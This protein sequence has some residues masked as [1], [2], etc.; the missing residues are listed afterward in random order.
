MTWSPDAPPFAT[1]NIL[2]FDQTRVTEDGKRRVIAQGVA[3]VRIIER[4]RVS[5]NLDAPPSAVWTEG[6]AHAEAT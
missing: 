3:V 4:Y 6:E 5:W 2:G 1:W